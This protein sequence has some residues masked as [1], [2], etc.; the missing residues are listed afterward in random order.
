MH[1]GA[2]SCLGHHHGLIFGIFLSGLQ[3]AVW[4][5]ASNCA[6]GQRQVAKEGGKTFFTTTDEEQKSKTSSTKFHWK[7]SGIGT[8]F[9]NR[10]V[11]NVE[12]FVSQGG[13]ILPDKADLY[14]APFTSDGYYDERLDFFLKFFT[15]PFWVPC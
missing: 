15:C 11:W 14:M 7:F 10:S 3:F 6:A 8:K 9:T 1:K 2:Q 4:E 13:A 5:H 12:N